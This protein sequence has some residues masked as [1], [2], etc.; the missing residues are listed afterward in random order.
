VW[1]G[2]DAHARGLVDRMGGFMEAVEA[3]RARA[4]VEGSEEVDLKVFGDA[5]GLFSS[6]GG[7]PSVM[8]R[9][10]PPSQPV[11][12]PGMQAILK[13]TGLTSGWLEPGLK[14][15]LPFSLTIE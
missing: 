4:K 9:L 10:L 3:A 6:L 15:A 14:A 2:K 12:P 5:R 8:T 11:L 13:Q 1:S 7:E